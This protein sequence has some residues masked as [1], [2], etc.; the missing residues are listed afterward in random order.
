MEQRTFGFPVD[1]VKG[2]RDAISAG[3]P[4]VEGPT[5]VDGRT[6]ERIRVDPPS[7][8]PCPG[9]PREPFYWYVDPAT[10]YPVGMEGPGGITSP[11]RPFLPLHVVVR[12]QAYEYLPRTGANLAL[13]SIRAQHPGAKVVR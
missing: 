5:T 11:G 13:A 6:V 12:Y 4:H 1:L 8:A 3:S 2:L 7:I 9:C 10:C